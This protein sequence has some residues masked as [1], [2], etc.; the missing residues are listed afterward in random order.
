MSKEYIHNVTVEFED[1]DSYKIA[2]HAKLVTYLE[3]ARVHFFSSLG[4]DLGNFDFNPVLYHL[5]IKFKKTVEL[6]DVLSIHV[7]IGEVKTFLLDINYKIRKDD[8][9]VAKAKATLAFVD[10]KT[11]ELLPVPSIFSAITKD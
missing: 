1:V 6:L 5:D 2:H 4:Y 8:Q 9:L 3:R 7:N 11:K 10:A